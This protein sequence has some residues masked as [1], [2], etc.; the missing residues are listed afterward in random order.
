MWYRIPVCG[1]HRGHILTAAFVQAE[2]LL[3]A[4]KKLIDAAAGDPSVQDLEI[5][6]DDIM[7]TVDP[8]RGASEGEILFEEELV[9]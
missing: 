3:D 8:P 2:T 1:H 5:L 7:A 9:H 6:V 4:G